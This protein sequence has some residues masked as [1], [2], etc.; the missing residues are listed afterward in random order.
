MKPTDTLRD[1]HRSVAAVAAVA[2]RQVKLIQAGERPDIGDLEHI[3]DFFRFFTVACHEPKEEDILFSRLHRCGVSRDKGPLAE[4]MEE[5]AELRQLLTRIG[6]LLPPARSGDD[7]ALAALAGYL[8]KYDEL[9]ISHMA[10]EEEQIFPLMESSLGESDIEYLT[11]EFGTV[12]EHESDLGLHEFY[13]DLA[14]QLTGTTQ[15]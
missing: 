3:I 10:A 9:V 12:A 7:E 13:M 6:H 1:E 2:E 4:M 5:H 8:H 15:E 14:R 11:E